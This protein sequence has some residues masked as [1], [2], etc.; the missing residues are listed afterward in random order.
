M[1][2]RQP[3]PGPL[4]GVYEDSIGFEAHPHR[5][6]FLFPPVSAQPVDPLGMDGP[7]RQRSSRE[8]KREKA[9]GTA[10]GAEAVANAHSAFISPCMYRT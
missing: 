4:D 6:I 3:V 2:A 8:N 5:L 9:R 10:E 1:H 7:N